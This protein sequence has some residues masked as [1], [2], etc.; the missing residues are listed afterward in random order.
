MK[1]KTYLLDAHIHEMSQAALRSYEMTGN[2]NSA[3]TAAAEYAIDE[4][5]IKPRLFAVLAAVKIAKAAWHGITL[6]VREVLRG[7]A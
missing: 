6:G 1:T 3:K 5:G 4:L 7:A 2:W